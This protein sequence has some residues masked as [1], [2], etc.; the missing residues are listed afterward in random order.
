MPDMPS[1]SAAS[2][3]RSSVSVMA[4]RASRT[5]PGCSSRS[6]DSRVPESFLA[7]DSG[8]NTVG[9]TGASPMRRSKPIRTIVSIC[10]L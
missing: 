2:V 4:S 7:S 3:K 6:A 1:V 9:I 5:R 8:E 10:W